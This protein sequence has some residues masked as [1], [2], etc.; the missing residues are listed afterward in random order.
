MMWIREL[1]EF[2]EVSRVIELPK[3][4]ALDPD[5]EGV[6]TQLEDLSEEA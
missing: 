2:L 4:P 6:A 5:H 1:K 3:I